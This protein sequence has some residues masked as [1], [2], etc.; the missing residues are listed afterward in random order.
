MALSRA[1]MNQALTE[2]TEAAA[3]AGNTAGQIR[4]A[5]RRAMNEA[6]ALANQGINVT[7]RRF[8]RLFDDELPQAA[9]LGGRLK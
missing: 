4:G 1:E 3:D 6:D 5:A 7:P 2:L 8:A 9:G